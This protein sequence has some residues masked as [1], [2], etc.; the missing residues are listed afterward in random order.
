MAT[1]PTRPRTQTEATERHVPTGPTGYDRQTAGLAPTTSIVAGALG[2][3]AGIIPRLGV[4]ALVLAGVALLAGLPTLRSERS[5][6]TQRYARIGVT[7]AVA[8][9]VLG[10][11]NIA[12]QLDMFAYFTADD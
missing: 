9:I 2:A 4:A 7:L 1:T 5:G 10:I 12:I 6:R 8:A 11:L 3:I